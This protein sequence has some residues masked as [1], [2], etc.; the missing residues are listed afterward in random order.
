MVGDQEE[1]SSQDSSW[2]RDHEVHQQHT[3]TVHQGEKHSLFYVDVRVLSD[4]VIVDTI[5]LKQIHVQL[6]PMHKFF[7]TRVL[8]VLLIAQR[9]TP[10]QSLLLRRAQLSTIRS[11]HVQ[12][13]E[14]PKYF[15]LL[16]VLALDKD[17]LQFK[18]DLPNQLAHHFAFQRRVLKLFNLLLRREDRVSKVHEHPAAKGVCF[19]VV[20]AGRN[21]R[22][23]LTQPHARLQ[24]HNRNPRLQLQNLRLVVTASLR[25]N[26]DR[27]TLPNFF[28]G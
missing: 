3:Q 12:S 4:D 6:Y 8:P 18:S 2:K 9:K 28:N 20:E 21:N 10:R 19:E 27:L 16:L 22:D 23:T 17:V 15:Q 1:G 24:R 14:R 25:K 5:V 7:Y 26:S 11:R 13:S